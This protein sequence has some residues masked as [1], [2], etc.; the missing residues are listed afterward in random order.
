MIQ[1]NI[2]SI[3]ESAFEIPLTLNGIIIYDQRSPL[4]SKLSQ[5][6]TQL[7]PQLTQIHFDEWT[8]EDILNEL[9]KQDKGSLAILVQSSNFRLNAFRLRVELF[10]RGIKVIEHLH[11][12]RMQTTL[13]QQLYIQSLEYDSQYYRPLGTFLKSQIDQAQKFVLKSGE[14]SEIHLESNTSILEL[15]K[16]N[17]GDY[18]SM[19]NAGGLFPIGEVITEPRDL[20]KLCG[21]VTLYTYANTNFEVAQIEKPI[22]LSIDQGQVVNVKNSNDEFNSILERIRMDEGVVW[23]REF[24][25]GLN[26]A[27]SPTQRVKD[28]ATFERVC[29]FHLSLGAKHTL[30]AKENLNKRHNKHHID[31]FVDIKSLKIND[32]ELWKKDHWHYLA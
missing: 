4:A 31:V 18:R 22:L 23:V 15:A 32:F 2:R 28:V 14:N 26:R 6:Y 30:F 8:Q 3:I 20:S 11:L 24:G 5:A 16:L 1:Q 17:V 27:F 25:F 9:H 13:E 10:N 29:G 19:K 21:E 12:E 7:L